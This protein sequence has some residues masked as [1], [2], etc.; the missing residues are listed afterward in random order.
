MEKSGEGKEDI[1]EWRDDD[2]SVPEQA[3]KELDNEFESE[4]R[5]EQDNPVP[6]GYIDNWMDDMKTMI[7]LIN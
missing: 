7:Y 5:E 2:S 4:M 3:E 1:G 6:E